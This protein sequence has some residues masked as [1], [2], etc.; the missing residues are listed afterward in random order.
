M[1]DLSSQIINSLTSGV[2]AVDAQGIILISNRAAGEHLEIGETHLTPG[3]RLETLRQCAPLL[4]VFREAVNTH[5]PVSRREV[6]LSLED[7]RKKE[8]GLSV[9][10][11][12]GPQTFNGVIFLF[13]D[14]TER[15]SLERAA[16]INRQLAALGALTAGVVHELRSPVSVISG[17]AELLLRRFDRD[18]DRRGSAETIFQEASNLKRTI[19]QFL[20]FARP[21]E[22]E[23]VSCRPDEIAERAVQLCRARL[24]KKAITLQSRY[25]AELPPLRADPGRVAQALA[26]IIDNA[27]DSS[28]PN[29][30]IRLE[31]GVQDDWVVFTIADHGPGIHLQP[32]EDIFAP[33]FTQKEGGTGLGLPIVHRIV[34]AHQG[35][36][37]YHNRKQ[38]GAQFEVRLPL[39]KP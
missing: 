10:L 15:R 19:S 3:A 6:T 39:E 11:L 7:G 34:T 32:G 8:I 20:G 23:R 29:R 16:E 36:V 33:F 35:N 12:E 24:Q 1:H 21:F 25:A 22:L 18:D 37:S 9:S 27:I 14:M 28:P 26:N 2:L 5:N 30:P 31:V 17:M 38:G 4:E 13:T